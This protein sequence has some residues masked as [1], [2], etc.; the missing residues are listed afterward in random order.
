M[1]ASAAAGAVSRWRLRLRLRW[2][3][4]WRLCSLSWREGDRSGLPLGGGVGMDDELKEEIWMDLVAKSR[5][6]WSEASSCGGR[7]L[8]AELVAEKEFVRCRK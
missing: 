6:S 7:S 1:A 5:S 4:C 3:S 2:Q 8:N